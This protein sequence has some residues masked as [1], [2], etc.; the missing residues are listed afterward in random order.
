MGPV[1][2]ATFCHAVPE[3]LSDIQEV[4]V[5]KLT[6]QIYV[7]PQGSYAL[8][9]SFTPPYQSMPAS[10]VVVIRYTPHG[11]FGEGKVLAPKKMNTQCD[12]QQ[13]ELLLAG[14][15][16][17]VAMMHLI[18][19]RLYYAYSNP[20]YEQ[21]I[22]KKN[23]VG[24]PF[25]LAFAQLTLHAP[26]FVQ[27]LYSVARTGVRQAHYGFCIALD[28][29]KNDV[30][31]KRYFDISFEPIY[32]KKGNSSG[33]T[34][35][36]YDVSEKIAARQQAEI[37]ETYYKTLADHLPHIIWTA[38]PDRKTRYHNAKW[39]RLYSGGPKAP[40]HLTFD[41]LIHPDDA[42]IL[43]ETWRLGE[44]QAKPITTELRLRS[45]DGSYRWFLFNIAP[46]YD[47]NDQLYEWF[48]SAT[49]IHIQKENIRR[50]ADILENMSDGFLSMD[51][52]WRITRVNQQEETLVKIPREQQIGKNYLD[53]FYPT[54][55]S[56]KLRQCQYFMQAM[57]TREHIYFED[58]YEKL[59]LYTAVHAYPDADG[60]MAIFFRDCGK[61]RRLRRNIEKERQK[62]EAIFLSSPACMALYRGDD[63]I[64]EKVNKAYGQSMHNRPLVGLPLIVAVPELIDQPIL[65]SIQTCWQ[66]GVPFRSQ[67]M[68]VRLPHKGDAHSDYSYFDVSF[69]CMRDEEDKPYGIYSHAEDVTERVLTRQRSE[70]LNQTL[71]DAIAAR[72]DFLSS[73]SHELK[74]P[75]TSIKMQLQ[76]T[77]RR[78]D[79]QKTM[80]LSHEKLAK[81]LYICCRQ[82]DK[83][84]ALIEDLLDVSR[85]AGGKMTFNFSST[86]IAQLAQDVVSQ[87]SGAI[88]VCDHTIQLHI[89]KPVIIV[90]DGFRIEQ[91]IT[92]LIT[93][94]IKYGNQSPIDI[95]IESHVDQGA[96]IRVVDRG[97]GI[98]Q[99]KQPKVFDRFERAVTHKNVSGLGLGLFICKQ[100][101]DAHG[102]SIAVDSE[103]GKD[104]T[105]TV[106]LP[107]QSQRA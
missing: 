64:I 68:P 15:P 60:G 46:I 30:I 26:Y 106:R 34:Y 55:K 79:P 86:N 41:D 51:K 24:K 105:F 97:M 103:L 104:S 96:C 47:K 88:E 16:A 94:A 37:N 2:C 33:V 11:D 78:L 99:D 87:F 65:A 29:S 19:G 35:F 42:E 54:E 100:I 81:T 45:T 107:G 25:G 89:T 93:N 58:C 38:E 56:Q 6:E 28:W 39:D 77:M 67:E 73:A 9:Y 18:D 92:N 72:D 7:T 21:L 57:H 10:I 84:T 50:F 1:T 63:F 14:A 62:F 83:L 49:D 48:G 22:G 52:D 43:E 13:L 76:M 80:A 98:A 4:F 85:I 75:V 101:V 74:T 53:V 69:T 71:Q 102:G 31:E 44:D 66:T 95:W 90:C 12:S 23:L 40:S 17:A 3:A 70:K 8:T 91:V 5:N 27:M 82:V 61:E 32:D 36:S 59:D 20:A